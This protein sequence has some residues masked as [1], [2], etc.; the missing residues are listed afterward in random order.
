MGSTGPVN[1]AVCDIEHGP[2][3]IVDLPSYKMM[4]LSI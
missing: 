4:D 1:L 3:E 2:V